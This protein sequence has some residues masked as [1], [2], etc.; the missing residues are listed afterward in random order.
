MVK[1]M[2]SRLKT[3]L[4]AP[5]LCI[6]GP[7]A[8]GKTQLAVALAQEL[9]AEIIS[10]DSR[11]VYKGM[12][13][14]T[15]KDLQEYGSVPYHLINIRTPDMPYDVGQYG[16][17]FQKSYQHI[18][19][20]GKPAILCGGSGLYL[21]AALQGFQQVQIPQNPELR[22]Y[23]EDLSNTA[24]HAHFLQLKTRNRYK[25]DIKTRKRLIRA[26]EIGQW[27][28][29]HPECQPTNQNKSA[30]IFGINPE[31]ELRRKRI[32]L[33]LEDRLQ[34]GLVAEVEGL[35]QHGVS[36][37]QLIR[38][39]LEYKFTCMYLDGAFP[40]QVYKT[41]LETAIHQFAKRQMTFFRKMEKDGLK[42]YWLK[43][44]SKAEQIEEILKKQNEFL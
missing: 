9:H 43:S 36:S 6:L 14:G 33:R 20:L 31:L 35:L 41:K 26:I 42:I 22:Q 34:A 30:H 32:S 38:Y 13:I 17:D 24:L 7:T 27:L 23:L 15:G 29:A 25:H 12:D 3:Q 10:A 19:S 4:S 44:N 8:S 28:E 18:Q 5:L 39:G 40:F 16:I 37:D 21:Q 2:K 1:V 11:Q